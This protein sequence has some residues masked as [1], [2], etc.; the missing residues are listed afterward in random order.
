MLFLY[1]KIYHLYKKIKSDH[2]KGYKTHDMGG[3]V[4]LLYEFGSKTFTRSAGT[5]N[6]LFQSPDNGCYYAFSFK[7]ASNKPFG[8]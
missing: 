6:C 8:Q 7:K 3:I 2:I 4:F 1:S 5:G